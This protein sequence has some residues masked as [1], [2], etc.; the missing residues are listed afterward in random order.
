MALLVWMIPWS[1]LPLLHYFH[2]SWVKIPMVLPFWIYPENFLSKSTEPSFSSLYR[3][4]YPIGLSLPLTLSPVWTPLKQFWT[5]TYASPFPWWW[6][7][8]GWWADPSLLEDRFP[9]WMFESCWGCCSL[10]LFLVVPGSG[11]NIQDFPFIVLEC[12]PYT[13][14][15]LVIFELQT[16]SPSYVSNMSH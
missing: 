11:S 15:M 16:P 1:D 6:V 3:K 12:R 10:Q 14:V 2:L 7:M 5:P 9:S 4:F 13:F 8:S